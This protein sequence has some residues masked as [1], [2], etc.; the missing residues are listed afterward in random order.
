MVAKINHTEQLYKVVAYNQHKV[1]AGTARIIGGHRMIADTSDTFERR[2]Q[3]TLLAFENHL[4]LNRNTEKPILHISLNPTLDDRLA[5]T[6]YAALARDYMEKM[7]Y[8]DQPYIVYLHEDIDRRHIHIVSTCVD[9]AGRKLND[10][11]EWRRSMKACRELERKYGLRDV[12]DK[13]QELTDT[14]L[15]KADYSRGDAKRQIGNIL[16]SLYRSYRYQTFGEWSALLVQFNIEAKQVRGEFQG[17]PYA[18]V[19]YTIADDAGRPLG[20]PVKASLIGREFGHE[21]LKRR[22]AYNAKEYRAGRWR[23]KIRNEVAAAMLRSRGD[24]EEFRRLLEE[25]HIGVLFRENEAGRIY[26]VTFIDHNAREVYNGSRLGREFSA[27]IFERL[28]HG[29]EVALPDIEQ[30]DKAPEQ[31][32]ATDMASAI[33]Q[34]FGLFSLDTADIPEDDPEEEAFARR[35]RRQAK[36]KKRRMRGIS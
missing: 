21:G 8:G 3:Q 12:A 15:R 17:E 6:Q 14:Y 27:N 23:P 36:K 30:S 28:F 24:R 9:D 5:E 18:G 13:R 34:A 4:L 31:S 22:M 10:K 11:Y 32:A 33:E 2:M 26:G 19:V 35:M 29:Q 25:K 20:T 16:K 7:G 1:D